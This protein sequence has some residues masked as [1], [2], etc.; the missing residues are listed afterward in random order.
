M[1]GTKTREQQLNIIEKREITKNAGEDFDA[2]AELKKS[3]REREAFRKGANLR[4]DAPNLVDPG[5]R[6]MPR[7]ENQ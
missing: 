6:N 1:A 2:E 7:G 4:T 5:D 3:K